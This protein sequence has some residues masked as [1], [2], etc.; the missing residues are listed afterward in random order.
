MRC[1]NVIQRKEVSIHETIERIKQTIR[2]FYRLKK[3][4]L[5]GEKENE[6]GCEKVMEKWRKPKIGWRKINCD[7]TLDLKTKVAGTGMIVR[8]Y[9]GEVEDGK[10]KRGMAESHLMEEALVVKEGVVLEI[11]KK[12]QKVEIEIDSRNFDI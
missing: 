6:E 12:W 10:C 11:E 2:E 1:E 4:V 8:D 9:K 3:D 7:A 5:G